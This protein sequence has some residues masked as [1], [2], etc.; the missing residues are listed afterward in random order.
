MKKLAIILLC[1]VGFAPVAMS[2]ISLQCPPCRSFQS[3]GQ[4][5]V[6]AAEA[7]AAG[8][9]AARGVTSPTIVEEGV[10]LNLSIERISLY[11]NPST[12]GYF[13]LG[14]P[15]RFVGEVKVADL[16]GRV[17]VTYLLQGEPEFQSSQEL[18]PG[19]YFILIND[20]EGHL[21]TKSLMVIQ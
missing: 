4:C 21:A 16:S 2:Q 11:P 9:T 17:V 7:T 6:D 15:E 10:E 20:K 14:N 3:C 8:C 5:W 19:L 1:M 12:D 13:T 18:K